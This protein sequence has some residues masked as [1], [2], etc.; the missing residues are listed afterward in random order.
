[1]EER[2]MSLELREKLLGSLPFSVNASLWY[3]PAKY[4][5][6]EEEF[7]PSF[8]IKSFTKEEFI[9]AKKLLQDVKNAKEETLNEMV[10]KKII[11]WKNVF[12]LGTLEEICYK[13]DDAAVNGGC[14]KVQFESIPPIIVGDLFFNIA[15]ISGLIDMDKLG[16]KS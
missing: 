5:D 10:R 16:L 2:K 12:D 14:D 9:K 15:K 4:K 6:V 8:E 1:L 13:S 11:N 3:S 7:R